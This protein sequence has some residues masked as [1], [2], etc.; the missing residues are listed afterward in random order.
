MKAIIVSGGSAPSRKL[1]EEEIDEDSILICADGGANCL[2]EYKIIP[3]YLIGDF[4]SIDK[5]VLTFFKSK[6][7][8]IDTY[9]RAKDFTDTEIAVEKSLELEVDQIVM[10]ACT[11][12]RIDHVL[13][14]LGMLLKC[15]RSGVKAYIKDEHNIIELLCKTTT[16]KGYPGETFSLHAYC[17]VVKN[18]N[19]IGARYKL[20]NYD[21]AL[22]D[23][24]TV[25]NEFIEEEARIVFD[26]GMLL[27]MHSKD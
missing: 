12:S 16:I 2:Y 4:D 14:N 8:S 5:N 9:P 13:A 26:S 25:S 10:L 22:G 7:C 6:K 11:G 21:L 27:C 19:I 15:N 23:A 17:N 24:R 1:I 20:S 3:D 18:L